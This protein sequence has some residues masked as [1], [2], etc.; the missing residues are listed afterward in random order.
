MK[1]RETFIKKITEV[2]GRAVGFRIDRVR[3]PDGKTATREYLDHPGAVAVL[4]FVG[5]DRIAMVEQ[6]RHPV[7]RTTWE[8]PAGKLGRN[9]KPGP[10]AHR[11]LAEETGYRARHMRR[12][13]SFWPT[14]AFANEIIHVYVATG[15]REGR[16]NPDEDEFLNCRV[17]KLSDVMRAIK[18]G[19]IKDAKTVIAVTAWAAFRSGMR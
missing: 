3:L 7:G 6:Y 17:W 14:A 12:L 16:T 1:T 11:E 4:A 19:R 18:S 9:E 2:R 8:I 15:L 10:C 13:V 5:P